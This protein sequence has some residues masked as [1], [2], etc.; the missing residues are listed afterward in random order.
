MWKQKLETYKY[1]YLVV[2][3][4]LGKQFA[5]GDLPNSAL[6]KL[7]VQMLDQSLLVDYHLQIPIKRENKL[8]KVEHVN[9]MI[10][11]Q[12]NKFCKMNLQLGHIKQIVWMRSEIFPKG[13]SE[14]GKE[15]HT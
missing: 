13:M 9:I 4:E 15:T 1:L 11:I 8:L 12:A 7:G 3:S 14:R 5:L 6:H 2:Q 10:N